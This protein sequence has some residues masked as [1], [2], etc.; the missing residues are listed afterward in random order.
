M[1]ILELLASFDGKTWLVHME[2][3]AHAEGRREK[4]AGR[5]DQVH[6]EVRY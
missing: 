3:Y 4:Q 5:L 6:Q 1:R 2:A